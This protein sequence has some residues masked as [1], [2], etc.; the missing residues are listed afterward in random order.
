M[1][2]SFRH[3]YAETKEISSLP[4][5]I[6]ECPTQQDEASVAN[7]PGIETQDLNFCS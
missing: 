1:R 2:L 4:W 5:F 6:L 7:T 3:G